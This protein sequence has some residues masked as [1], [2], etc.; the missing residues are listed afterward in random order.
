MSSAPDYLYDE[1]PMPF[2]TG[3][4]RPRR[5]LMALIGGCTVFAAVAILWLVPLFRGSATEQ[6]EQTAFV[7]VAALSAGDTA[8]AYSLLCDVERARLSEEELVAEYLRPGT[9]SIAASTEGDRDG[10]PA[11]TV[12][13][14]WDDGGAGST[15]ELTLVPENGA[16]IC[17]TS[18]AG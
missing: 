10:A 7:F 5:R 17:G 2:H 6:S 1:D 13:V 4:P 18:P 9:G 14:R 12:E 8:T 15:S 3:T 11:V 16:R